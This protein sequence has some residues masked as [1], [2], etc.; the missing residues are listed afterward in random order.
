MQ[1]FL[2]DPQ[3]LEYCDNIL[4]LEDGEVRE[5]G[6][7]KALMKANDRYAQLFR[8][9]QME[10][11]KVNANPYLFFKGT[12]ALLFLACL[13]WIFIALPPPKTIKRE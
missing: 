9:Y 10:Q 1:C 6:D 12:L 5:A 3:Y 4:V 2:C 7:H 13:I 8:N 11:A